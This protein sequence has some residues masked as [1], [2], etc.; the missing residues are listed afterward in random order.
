MNTV[1]HASR[2]LPESTISGSGS[3]QSHLSTTNSQQRLRA[4]ATNAYAALNKESP[5]SDSSPTIPNAL[6]VLFPS[7][8]TSVQ[9]P[10]R[11]SS[12]SWKGLAFKWM[13]LVYCFLSIIFMSTSLYR[14]LYLVHA[15]RM[16]PGNELGGPISTFAAPRP[17][18]LFDPAPV[19]SPTEFLATEQRLLRLSPYL[20]SSREF[21]PHILLPTSLAD[22]ITA[23]LWSTDDGDTSFQALVSW[24]SK[25]TG[26]QQVY[27][28]L[29][30]C[31]SHEARPNI[32]SDGNGD[33]PAFD[34]ASAA[35]TTTSNSSGS[36]ILV[37]SLV[38]PL[39]RREQ[40]ALSFCLSKPSASF[41]EFPHRYAIPCKS[42]KCLASKSLQRPVT[43]P[44]SSQKATVDYKH[45]Y[46]RIFYP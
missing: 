20:G 15:V 21:E 43:R 16:P 34:S 41:R 29:V 42:F 32:S 1:N 24:A 9:S 26:K 5:S 37:R 10:D 19:A 3:V 13:A 39:S 27:G 35:A 46:I 40:P 14:Y 25:W 6:R 36:S 17:V 31:P 30:D 4:Q 33:P 22:G 28:V 23:C 44:P 11:H 38:T 45:R 12:R 2:P 18:F 7:P 8:E